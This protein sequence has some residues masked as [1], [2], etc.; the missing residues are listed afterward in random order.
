MH[1]IFSID[2]S[3]EPLGLELSRKRKCK[4]NNFPAISRSKIHAF[5]MNFSFIFRFFVF[6]YITTPSVRAH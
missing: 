2:T 4:I 5:S 1:V 3:P 6:S